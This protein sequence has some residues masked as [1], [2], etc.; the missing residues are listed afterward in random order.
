MNCAKQLALLL[1]LAVVVGCEGEAAASAASGRETDGVELRLQAKLPRELREVSGLAST[2]EQTVLAVA[3]ERAVVFEIDP[4]VARI[5]KRLEIGSPVLTGDFEGIELVGD[6]IYLVDSDGV[7]VQA[8]RNRPTALPYQRTITGAGATC[9]IEGL[10]HEPETDLLYLLCKK[11][12]ARAF[13][14]DTVMLLAYSMT[15]RNLVPAA[16]RALNVSDA[17]A[18]LELKKLAPSG[19]AF[20]KDP[21]F[22]TVVAA[23][24]QALIVFNR[25]GEVISAQ[26]LPAAGQHQQTEGIAILADGRLVLADEGNSSAGRLSVYDHVAY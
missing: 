22:I 24:Q 10:S 6:A 9:E 20:G 18:A 1:L 2:P 23:K 13:K 14:S 7:I 21:A 12:R 11:P 5:V 8:D 26:Y 25:S 4:T 17:L 15:T 19:L 3:D 16:H